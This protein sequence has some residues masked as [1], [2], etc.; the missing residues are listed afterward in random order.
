[1]KKEYVKLTYEALINLLQ[2]KEIHIIMDGNE[3][4]ILPPFDGVFMTHE[5]IDRLRH[6]SQNRFFN[7]VENFNQNI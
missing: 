2:G 7:M 3:F 1:M 4:V 5:E 6:E